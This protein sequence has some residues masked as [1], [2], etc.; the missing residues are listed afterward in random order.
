VAAH[1]HAP[2]EVLNDLARRSSNPYV[3]R[4]LAS[5]PALQDSTR[6]RLL[7]ALPDLK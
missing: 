4:Q 6:R 3:L 2:P 5:N 7:G 1:A